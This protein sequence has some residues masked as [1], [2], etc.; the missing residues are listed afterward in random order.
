MLCV[1]SSRASYF[2]R[3]ATFVGLLTLQ[4][5]RGARFSFP[6]ATL[7]C[8]EFCATLPFVVF[9][10]LRV[11]G[12]SGGILSLF[13]RAP[14]LCSGLCRG[15]FVRGDDSIADERRSTYLNELG[16]PIPPHFTSS[17]PP[18]Q[19]ENSSTTPL[20]PAYLNSE[21]REVSPIPTLTSANPPTPHS[22]PIVLLFT[23]PPHLP[24]STNLRT[25]DA[26]PN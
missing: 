4:P 13:A 7:P 23:L 2:C 19:G 16:I 1:D 9:T 10:S 26:T 18:G 17:Q 11:L 12:V 20:P 3:A 21:A 22:Y 5:A 15:W 24:P 6:L 8:P 14:R 25:L